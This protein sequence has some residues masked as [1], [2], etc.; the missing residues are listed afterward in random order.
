MDT[1][2]NLHDTHVVVTGGAGL[3]GSSVVSAFRAV[4]ANVTS[5]DITY[6]RQPPNDA[7]SSTPG[8]LECHVDTTSEESI[9]EA[10]EFAVRHHGPVSV[11]IALAALDLSVLKHHQSSTTMSA[12]Q[13]RRT[14]DVNVVGTFITAREWLRGL[15][16]LPKDSQLKNPTLIIIG[17]ESG[18]FGEKS[19]AD[20]ST[21]KSAVQGGLL[22][23]LAIDAPR[24]WQGARYGNAIIYGLSCSLGS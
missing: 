6:P 21:S 17:S 13:F 10:F 5:L 16:A 3:I 2:F 24:V 12:E 23:S 1:G 8:Y 22:K 7:V 19:N 15:S 14:L 11:C 20:Y 4:H 9:K 18:M